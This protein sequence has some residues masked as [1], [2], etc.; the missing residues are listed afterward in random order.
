MPT[1][2]VPAPGVGRGSLTLSL[3]PRGYETPVWE[4]KWD[5]RGGHG[6]AGRANDNDETPPWFQRLRWW[7]GVLG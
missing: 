6:S 3:H 7:G 5:G 1:V 4:P 2:S